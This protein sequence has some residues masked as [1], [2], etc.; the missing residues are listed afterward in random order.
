MERF[1]VAEAAERL[2]ISQQAV[3]KRLQRGTLPHAKQDGRVYVY[4]DSETTTLSEKDEE[5]SDR[6]TTLNYLDKVFIAWQRWQ[7]DYRRLTSLILIVSVVLLALSGGVIATD[8]K[9]TVSGI[10]L[11][12]PLVVFMI[13]GALLIPAMFNMMSNV[14]LLAEYYARE[15]RILYKTLEVDESALTTPANPFGIGT[16]VGRLGWGL[17]V[18]MRT[19]RAEKYASYPTAKR[20]LRTRGAILI[21]LAL[22]AI[23]P[24]A[25]QTGAG[26]RISELLYQEDPLWFPKAFAYI[27]EAFAY[28]RLPRQDSDWVSDLFAILAFVTPILWMGSSWLRVPEPG[29]TQAEEEPEEEIE[30][31]R[32]LLTVGAVLF[33]LVFAWMGIWLGYFV[34][35]S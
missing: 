27:G 24:A 19:A 15:M 14:R 16:V 8:E 34:A 31:A 30:G 5:E 33:A 6:Q 17:K 12:V 2:E 25:A 22:Y 32:V 28:I 7:L 10:G 9:L 18:R 23:L 21:S 11:R 1:T 3:R 4:L 29:A 20:S 35:A 13:T 26:Y